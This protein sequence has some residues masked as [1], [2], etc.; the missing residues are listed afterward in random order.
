MTRYADQAWPP[1]YL[2][3]RTSRPLTHDETGVLL[4]LLE[5]S[6]SSPEIVE[7][8]DLE[9]AIT[10]IAP[11]LTSNFNLSVMI[12]RLV[13]MRP[14]LSYSHLTILLCAMLSDRV[15]VAVQWAYT[16]M[17]FDRANGR[18]MTLS[19]WCK[20]FPMGPPTLAEQQTLWDDQKLSGRDREALGSDNKLDGRE[21]WSKRHETLRSRGRSFPTP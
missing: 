16:I 4:S 5:R 20:Q 12:K 7:A 10:A 17:D 18:P 1:S 19:D 6:Y 2:V 9:V 11:A 14:D 3:A 13:A 15:G 8:N 21:A